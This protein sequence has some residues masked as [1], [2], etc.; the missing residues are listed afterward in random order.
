MSDFHD[1]YVKKM[2]LNCY[3]QAQTVWSMKLRQ[4]MFM[5]TFINVGKRLILV[6][7]QK[8]QSFLILSTTKLPVK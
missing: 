3:F 6:I 4:K 7:F 5:E 2:T 8:T 1:A